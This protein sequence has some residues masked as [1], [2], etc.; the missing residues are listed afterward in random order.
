MLS[1]NLQFFIFKVEGNYK[2][3]INKYMLKYNIIFNLFFNIFIFI[4]IK[5]KIYSSKKNMNYF[6]TLVE[7]APALKILYFASL[8]IQLYHENTDIN[9]EDYSERNVFL[10]GKP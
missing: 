7:V 10:F 2:L 6:E 3:N 4:I 1:T 8:F 5:S 9:I